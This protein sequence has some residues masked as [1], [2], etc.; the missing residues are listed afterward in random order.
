[1][2]NNQAYRGL[3]S[4]KKGNGVF[5]TSKKKP[6]NKTGKQPMVYANGVY[7]NGK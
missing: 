1:M 5:A 6:A 3:Q 2:Q 4:G 7:K